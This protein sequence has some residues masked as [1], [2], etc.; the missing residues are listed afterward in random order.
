MYTIESLIG[1]QI[2]FRKNVIPLQPSENIMPRKALE[3]LSSDFNH[4]YSLVMDSDYRG[5][6]IHNAYAGTEFSEELVET[7]EKLAISGTDFGF[8]DVRPISGHIAALQVLGNILKEGEKF[9]YIPEE[10][11]GYDGYMQQYIPSLLHLKSEKIP[12]LNWKIDYQKLGKYGKDYSAIILGASIF[13]HPYDLKIVREMFPDS[14]ILYDAS[15]ILGLIMQGEFQKN[16]SLIDV[17]YGSTHKNFPGPQGGLILG[18]KDL[19]ENVK[20]NSIWKYYDNF[21]LGRIAA[22]G[23]SLEFLKNFEYAKKC[24]Q[25][26]QLLLK[27]LVENGVSIYNPP[28]FTE[29]CMMMINHPEVARI[30][31]QLEKNN[32]LIDRIGRVGLNEVTM[33]GL[34]KEHILKI[35]TMISEIVNGRKFLNL[36]DVLNILGD[37]KMP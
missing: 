37:I 5:I 15:H 18:R 16:L 1:K 9:L 8:S 19:E 30:S 34:S 14:Y 13:F 24:I 25:N 17:L 23:I 28:E 7:V 32:I 20:R 21:H 10:W 6:R 31:M 35:S 22:L 12:M 3:A 33:M 27:G 26:T 36:G 29:S 11:G 4:R 2:S